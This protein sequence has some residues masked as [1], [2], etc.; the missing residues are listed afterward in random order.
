MES[1]FARKNKKVSACKLMAATIN[2]FS[3]PACKR[4]FLTSANRPPCKCCNHH[5]S[6][7]APPV[8]GMR[9]LLPK[10][11]NST[12]APQSQPLNK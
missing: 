2:V 5:S 4:L 9:R 8:T 3:S 10:H 6:A 11:L 7:T 1:S 12:L